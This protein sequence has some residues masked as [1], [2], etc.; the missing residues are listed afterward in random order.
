MINSPQINIILLQYSTAWQKIH[1]ISFLSEAE[2]GIFCVF[3]KKRGFFS[4][5]Y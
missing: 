4:G 5:F 1:R 3:L 2:P